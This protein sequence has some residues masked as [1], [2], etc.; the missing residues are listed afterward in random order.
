MQEII[1][2]SG[3]EKYYG[4]GDQVTKAVDRVSFAVQQ[5]E[6][7]G[8]MGASGSGK[9]TLL[10]LLSTIDRVTAGHIYYG[11]T[12]ITEL[13]EE[14]LSE[15]R[16]KQL[17]FIFQEYNLLDT[18]TLE[19]NIMLVMTLHRRGKKEIQKRCR[20][21][22][23][24]LGIEEVKDKYPYQVSGGQKQRLTIARAVVKDPEILILDDSASALDFA[25]DAR[26]RAA[27][28]N[29]KGNKTIFIV[30]QRTSSIQFA[31]QILVMD[32]GQAVGLGTHEELLENCEI[33]REIYESQFKKED[34]R[35]NGGAGN[36]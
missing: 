6:F 30:S 32:D 19:E 7:I 25:T 10:N 1:R 21:L 14:Q 11:D 29:L 20:E 8:V 35:K 13:G 2:V 5:G 16:K 3:V 31:D 23:R 18:L 17:G 4:N 12:D 26:L 15:F 28:R 24:I 36:V 9:T 22:L 33:Y 27:L 34:L